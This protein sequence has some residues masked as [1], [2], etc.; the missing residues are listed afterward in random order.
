MTILPLRTAI[1]APGADEILQKSRAVYAALKT[2]TDS[3]VVDREYGQVADPSHE[4]HTFH[5]AFRS[6]RK[7]LF[8][9]VRAGNVDRYIAWGDGA[10]FHSYWK[11]TG[12]TS[13]YPKGQ[14]ANAFL[15]GFSPT[16]TSIVK[17]APWLFPGAGLVGTL[18]EFQPVSVAGTEKID[19]HDCLKLVGKAQSVYGATGHI[20]DV[21]ATSV[22]IDVQSFLVRRIFEDRTEGKVASRT[23]TS[24]DP[25]ANPEI[26]D[27][28][29]QVTP[30]SH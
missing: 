12:S 6:P 13:D 30:P 28:V 14:G 23:T 26:D 4:H 8:D 5:T 24:F 17:I 16:Y 27:A 15:S 20:S 7:F 21:R 2:Y 19:G 1:A 9:F 25:R 11:S 22:W 10:N 18:T 29:F 3:G